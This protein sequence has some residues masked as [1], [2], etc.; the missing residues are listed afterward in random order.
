L[1]GQRRPLRNDVSSTSDD[2]GEARA[3]TTNGAMQ[4]TSSR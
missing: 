2:G 4:G 3:M 1:F